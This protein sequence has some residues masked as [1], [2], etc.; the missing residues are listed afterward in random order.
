[1]AS[2]A[3]KWWEKLMSM[4]TVHLENEELRWNWCWKPGETEF[5]FSNF[6]GFLV[7]RLYHRS[8]FCEVKI[9]KKVHS[10]LK[11]F[12]LSNTIGVKENLKLGSRQNQ[13]ERLKKTCYGK[14]IPSKKKS[15]CAMTFWCPHEHWHKTC[16]C[17][18][19]CK[20]A[21]SPFQRPPVWWCTTSHWTSC[22][23]WMLKTC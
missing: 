12:R 15:P 10:I 11:N 17:V 5:A 2:T 1:M 3:R 20:Q 23:V 8:V 4:V 16:I 13:H 21:C 9:H 18:F 19:G 6:F 7:A 22:K 14:N